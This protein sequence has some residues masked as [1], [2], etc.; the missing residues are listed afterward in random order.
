MSFLAASSTE[1]F[2]KGAAGFLFFSQ[3]TNHIFDWSGLVSHCSDN[4]ENHG[5]ACCSCVCQS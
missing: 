3:A 1:T 2:Q 4:P 5:E